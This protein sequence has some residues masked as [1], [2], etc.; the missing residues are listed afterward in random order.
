MNVSLAIFWIAHTYYFPF[1]GFLGAWVSEMQLN[2]L[3]NKRY[4]DRIYSNYD[5][6]YTFRHGG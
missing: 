2:I 5:K 3:Y 1:F 4:Y 6:K